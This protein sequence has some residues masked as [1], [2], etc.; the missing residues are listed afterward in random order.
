MAINWAD[1]KVV[2]FESNRSIYS[3]YVQMTQ[4][5]DWAIL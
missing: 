1:A 2:S 4:A 5:R 3:D